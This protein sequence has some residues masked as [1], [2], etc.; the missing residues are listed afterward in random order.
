[1][2][3]TSIY[4]I[5]LDTLVVSGVEFYMKQSYKIAILIILI[6][7]TVS[8]FYTYHRLEKEIKAEEIHLFTTWVLVV[9]LVEFIVTLLL[10]PTWLDIMY[11]I[12]FLFSIFIRVL[13]ACI[14][15]PIEIFVGYRLYKILQRL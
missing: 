11:G 9:L 13:K 7:F 14:M 5:S 15:I 8:L 12:P 2:V 4:F 3:V 10:T 1:M 6:L